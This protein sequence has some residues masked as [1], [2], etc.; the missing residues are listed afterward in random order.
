MYLD[1]IIQMALLHMKQ[2]LLIGTVPRVRPDFPYLEVNL[3]ISGLREPIGAAPTLVTQPQTRYFPD[4][5]RDN[6]L[7]NSWIV[8][9]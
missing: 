6:V 7:V 3:L 5:R 1:K 4:K 9:Y 2:E 8:L